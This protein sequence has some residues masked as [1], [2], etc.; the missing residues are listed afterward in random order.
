MSNFDFNV[1]HSNPQDQ[2]LIFEIRKEMKI[3]IKQYGQKSNRNMSLLKLLKSLAIKAS[4]FLT[5]L[6]SSDPNE[7]CNRKKVLLQ[8]KQARNNSKIFVEEIIAKA[9]K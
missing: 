9:D 4:A 5:I 6:L 7:L 8:E 2:T 3:D 1:A